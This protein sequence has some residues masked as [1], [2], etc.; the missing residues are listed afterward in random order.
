LGRK[1]L[2]AEKSAADD[3]CDLKYGRGEKGGVEVVDE[4][5]EELARDWRREGGERR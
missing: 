2:R 3:M 4:R 1:D 5:E